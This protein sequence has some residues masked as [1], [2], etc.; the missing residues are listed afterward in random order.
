MVFVVNTNLNKPLWP[1]EEQES[2][3]VRPPA[4]PV[5]TLFHTFKPRASRETGFFFHAELFLVSKRR[6]L[7]LD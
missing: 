3:A 1:L 6:F 5:M 2:A 7:D 4:C